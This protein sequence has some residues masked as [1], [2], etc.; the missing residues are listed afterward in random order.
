MPDCSRV[1]K[2]AYP[3]RRRI[4]PDY[5]N[6]IGSTGLFPRR[7]VPESSLVLLGR[8]QIAEGLRG[9]IDVGQFGRLDD[10]GGDTLEEKYRAQTAGVQQP[11]DRLHQVET[12]DGR[13]W[14]MVTVHTR[15]ANRA[16][17]QQIDEA[18]DEGGHQE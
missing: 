17:A 16:V 12:V 18:A 4:A 5:H 14:M 7:E 15:D 10:A 11:S 3:L 2:Y 13:Q 6:Q 9:W 1:F 8:V